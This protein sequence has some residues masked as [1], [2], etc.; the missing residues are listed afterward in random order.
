M[1]NYGNW[2]I[3]NHCLDLVTCGLGGNGFIGGIVLVSG[4]SNSNTGTQEH[5]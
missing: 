3:S 4:S 2:N 1:N 5:Y